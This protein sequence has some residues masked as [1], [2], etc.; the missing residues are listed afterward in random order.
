MSSACVC[1]LNER[2]FYCEVY[3]PVEK[4]R[5]EL[6]ERVKYLEGYMNLIIR[7]ADYPIQTTYSL[8]GHMNA[9]EYAKHAMKE[10]GYEKPSK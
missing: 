6:R 4:E 3:K 2:C 9:V 10:V 1:H 5:D 8:S 7:T